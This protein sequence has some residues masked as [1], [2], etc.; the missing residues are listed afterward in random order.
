MVSAGVCANT[1]RCVF[2]VSARDC[3]SRF[4]AAT[5]LVDQVGQGGAVNP[6]QEMVA[7]IP[8]QSHVRTGV[9]RQLGDEAGCHQWHIHRADERSFCARF[10]RG[11]KSPPGSKE[12]THSAN[13]VAQNCRSGKIRQ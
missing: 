2:T 12:W 3:I 11:P 5:K 7:P 6:G 13:L 9:A 10:S 1:I 8:G 4:P